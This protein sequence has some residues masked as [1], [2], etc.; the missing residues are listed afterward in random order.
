M[1]CCIEK[2]RRWLIQDRLFVNDD[3]TEFTVIGTYRP[4]GRSTI[5]TVNM[6]LAGYEHQ[7]R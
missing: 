3:K 5:P 4:I 6:I 1:E 7:S 2:I